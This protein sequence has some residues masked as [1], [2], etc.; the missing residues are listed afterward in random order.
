M[1]F[2]FEVKFTPSYDTRGEKPNY[3]QHPMVMFFVLKG[4]EGAIVMELNTGW[5]LS[6]A[7]NWTFPHS[8]MKYNIHQPYVPEV[9]LHRHVNS[10]DL[11]T[12][13]NE[14][15]DDCGWLDGATCIPERIAGSSEGHLWLLCLIAEGAKGIEAKMTEVYN[16]RFPNDKP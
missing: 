1:T 7:K 8:E 5:L 13:V 15:R 6:E 2:Q 4:P 3:G 12:D 9:Y 16:E 14:M 10:N 11:H